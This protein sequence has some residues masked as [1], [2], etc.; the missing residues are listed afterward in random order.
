MY[1][2][3][4][5]C[6]RKTDDG[7][8]IPLDI[9]NRHYREY[10]D[11]VEEGNEPLPLDEDFY[12]RADKAARIDNL[13]KLK[14]DVIMPENMIN[15]ALARSIELVS[16]GVELT[17]Q[18]QAEKDHINSVWARVKALREHKQS[19]LTQLANDASID[20]EADWPE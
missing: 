9:A 6:I 1:Q 11:W 4:K 17:P 10:L 5:N 16:K 14:V 2:L 13:Y 8:I 15:F 12:T 19:L 18:E 3:L 7:L 20:V